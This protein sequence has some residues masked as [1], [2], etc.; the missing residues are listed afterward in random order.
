[1]EP[2]KL[3]RQWLIWLSI[4]PSEDNTNRWMKNIYSVVPVI[5]LFGDLC[6]IAA[7]TIYHNCLFICDLIY[8]QLLKTVLS[9]YMIFKSLITKTW[10]KHSADEI[11]FPAGMETMIWHG[12]RELINIK[13]ICQKKNSLYEINHLKNNKE[14]KKGRFWLKWNWVMT[15]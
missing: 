5:V 13:F 3:N 14:I 7:G 4:Y 6:G 10:K 8:L 12:K 2:F 15:F 9:Y 1:M 11:T